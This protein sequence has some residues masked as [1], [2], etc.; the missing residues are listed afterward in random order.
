MVNYES[1]YRITVIDYVKV[2]RMFEWRISNGSVD[3][4]WSVKLA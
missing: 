4:G 2:Y 3:F 1:Y